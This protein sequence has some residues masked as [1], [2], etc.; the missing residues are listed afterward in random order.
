MHHIFLSTGSRRVTPLHPPPPD[1]CY[2]KTSIEVCPRR[3]GCVRFNLAVKLQV[4]LKTIVFDRFQDSRAIPWDG[5]TW[6]ADYRATWYVGPD[7]T[8]DQMERVDRWECA[9][10]NPCDILSH[11]KVRDGHH[12]WVDMVKLRLPFLVI[13][14][15]VLEKVVLN[16]QYILLLL[17][18]PTAQVRLRSNKFAAVW[19]HWNAYENQLSVLCGELAVG[20]RQRYSNAV[21]YWDT[22]Q[23]AR[24]SAH[25]AAIY[26]VSARSGVSPVLTTSSDV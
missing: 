14:I 9:I 18:T 12:V 6:T 11:G 13:H 26:E 16:T 22:C 2:H 7:G 15:V 1:W 24:A 23:R 17:S 4:L 10:R 25:W 8:I 20:I 19:L 3:G 5:V 21:Q